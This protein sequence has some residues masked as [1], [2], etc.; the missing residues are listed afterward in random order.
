M[1]RN[2]GDKFISRNLD[3][4]DDLTEKTMEWWEKDLFT[5]IKRYYLLKWLGITWI[6]FPVYESL[7]K[8]YFRDTSDILEVIEELQKNKI[9][10]DL[11][12]VSKVLEPGCSVGQN[13]WQIKKKF[14]C[15]IYGVDISEEAIKRAKDIFK[16]KKNCFFEKHNVLTTNYFEKLNNN[17][18]DLI[19]IR[20]HLLNMPPSNL[21]K[22]Y[23]ELLKKKTKC[24]VVMEQVKD[25]YLTEVYHDGKY[26]LAWENWSKEYNLKEFSLKNL[27]IFTKL[28]PSERVYYFLS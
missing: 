14:D 25:N 15:Q 16:N 3:P 4:K 27:K 12:K 10:P 28:R 1:R 13:L 7:D 24:L 18:F 20:N 9:I 22:N 2:S 5:K 17:Y 23:V 6:K 19:L 11:C 21:K 8:N 26:V